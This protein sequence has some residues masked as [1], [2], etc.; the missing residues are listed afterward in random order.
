MTYFHYHDISHFM[1]PQKYDILVTFEVW[2]TFVTVTFFNLFILTKK[3][4][5]KL[6]K[7]LQ[8]RHLNSLPPFFVTLQPF[9]PSLAFLFQAQAFCNKYKARGLVDV[10]EG[11]LFLKVT[12]MWQMDE[13][14]FKESEFFLGISLLKSSN[15]KMHIKDFRT[16]SHRQGPIGVCVGGLRDRDHLFGCPNHSNRLL[17]NV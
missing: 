15:W 4:P 12:S 17:G 8:M 16:C 3:Y 13:K 6:L 11:L 1:F 2:Q 5:L 14:K 7:P 9:F 10:I